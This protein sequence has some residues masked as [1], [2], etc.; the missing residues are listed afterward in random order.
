MLPWR[1]T[2]DPYAVWIS[3]VMLQQTQ[4]KTVIPYFERFLSAFPNPESLAAA[5][6]QEVLKV[7]E[8]LGYYARARNLHRAAR[9]I[10]A[11]HGGTLPKSRAALKSLP[12]IG[13][14][15]AAAV[16]SIAFG[17]PHAVV[18]GNV[19]RVLAR[20]HKMDPPVNGPTSGKVFQ[21]AAD[22]F[23]ETS[24]PG[25]FNQAVM[26][27][28]ALICTPKNPRCPACPLASDCLALKT[29]AVTH[30]P[31]RIKKAKV[32]Q[33][34]IAV[35]VIWKGTKV[36][37]TRRKE[38][39]LLG[40]LW[41]FP[42]GKIKNGETSQAACAREI[43]EEVNL[44]VEPEERIARIRHAYTHFKIVMDVFQCTYR[45]GRVYLR[46]PVDFRWIRLQEMD[47]FPFPGANR[48]FI[49]LI[50]SQR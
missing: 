32:P 11:H 35:G 24:N 43:K 12:G 23:L 36:L 26:E 7:W 9:T 1:K 45:K 47:K 28:G 14:Y 30:Y 31:K 21:T 50:V 34:H 18:D 38:E 3:E 40:G 19:K 25:E 39:G 20:F 6:L 42:G 48:K 33:Y 41:E 17:K 46:G 37:I 13:D 22:A 10:Q 16:S 49:P 5:N 44:L 29:N 27:L 8:G 4:V 15:V 2:Q